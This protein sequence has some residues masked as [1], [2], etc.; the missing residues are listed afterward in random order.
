[1]FIIDTN[2]KECYYMY[3]TTQNKTKHQHFKCKHKKYLVI[4]YVTEV[5][6]NATLNL[7]VLGCGLQ[8]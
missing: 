4:K 8:F 6:E 3:S 7:P 2:H 1:M 5:L